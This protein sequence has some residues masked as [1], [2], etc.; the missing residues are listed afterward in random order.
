MSFF[1]QSDGTN[2]PFLVACAGN[3]VVM[4]E[5]TSQLTIVDVM[6][7]HQRVQFRCLQCC[8]SIKSTNAFYDEP[9]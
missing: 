2:I 6:I 1:G 5:K 7:W 9:S 4:V 3:K 8:K